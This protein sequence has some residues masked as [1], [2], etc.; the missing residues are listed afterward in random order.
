MGFG[1]YLNPF[2]RAGQLFITA[3]QL[4]ATTCHEMAHQI[5]L[6]VKVSAIL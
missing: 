3:V 2:T 4:S 1:G 5:G 6:Q